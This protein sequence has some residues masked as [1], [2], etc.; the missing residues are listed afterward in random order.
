MGYN[1]GERRWMRESSFKSEIGHAGQGE[2]IFQNMLDNEYSREVAYN[3][4]FRLTDLIA[5]S[6]QKR[7][8]IETS[9]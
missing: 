8:A 4:A 3:D 7:N 1:R 9:E 5:D 2:E 6:I